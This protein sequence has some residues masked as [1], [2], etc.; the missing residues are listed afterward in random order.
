MNVDARSQ[1]LNVALEMRREG[2]LLTDVLRSA[3]VV[4][5]YLIDGGIPDRVGRIVSTAA[6]DAADGSA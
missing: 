1:A 4:E 2:D 5:L 3:K 6:N